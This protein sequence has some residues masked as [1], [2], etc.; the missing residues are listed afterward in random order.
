[1]GASLAMEAAPTRWRGILSGILQSGYSI[2]YLL[3]AVATRFRIARM[4]LAADVLAGALPALLALYI[5]PRCRSRRRGASSR[6]QHGR[7]A[8]AWWRRTT[9]GFCTL[10]WLMVFM[11]FFR[12]ARGFVSGLFEG[13]SQGAPSRVA[14]IAMNLQRRSGDRGGDIWI[15]VAIAWKRKGMM[16]ALGLCLL[17]MPFWRLAGACRCWS[18]RPC[19]CR[20]ACRERGA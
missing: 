12:T 16:A 1:V 10:W 13:D 15:V 4:G 18:R 7:S 14:N 5:A 3:A 11:M 19:S 9:N 20:W 17:V 2:G 8:G 6:R